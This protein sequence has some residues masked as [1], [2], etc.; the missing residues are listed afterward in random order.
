MPAA[1]GIFNGFVYFYIAWIN[2]VLLPGHIR[3]VNAPF[4]FLNHIR[5]TTSNP[6]N[7]YNNAL[8]HCLATGDRSFLFSMKEQI[9]YNI[10]NYEIMPTQSI[11]NNH[12]N[13]S[14]NDNNPNPN[15]DALTQQSS[16][17]MTVNPYPPHFPFS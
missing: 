7:R 9:P 13:N 14:S 6:T 11:N 8:S 3:D 10:D 2:G 12:G 15:N 5:R 4:Y 17:I 16:F 1:N